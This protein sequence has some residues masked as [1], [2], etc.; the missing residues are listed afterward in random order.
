MGDICSIDPLIA[1]GDRDRV[2]SEVDAAIRENRGFQVEY[3]IIHKDGSPRAF[4]ER[5]QPV[6]DDEGLLSIDGIIQDVTA[7]IAAE[8]EKEKLLH[9]LSQKNAELEQFTYTVSH[10]LKSPLITI[11]GFLGYLEK[12]ALAG[13]TKQLHEDIA[14]IHTATSKMEKFMVALLELSRIGRFVNPPVR[15]SLAFLVQDTVEAL[16]AQ[17]RERGVTLLIP[18]DLPEIYGDRVRLQQVMTNL[19]ENA[20]KFMGDREEPRIEISA[21][22]KEGSVHVCIQDNGIGIAP[23]N[24]DKV[25]SV[26]TRLDP[27]IP[28]SGIGLAL[29]RRII[30][31]HGGQCQV[32]SAGAGMGSTFCFTLPGVPVSRGNTDPP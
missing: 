5:G 15:V 30:E 16:D 10:D 22:Q 8:E 28:G 4:I 11:K 6:Y 3:H 23:E 31:V 1:P 17:I 18:G 26:F 32:E 19:I 25:F 24:L 14:R 9:D 2:I 29:V 20:V 21:Y 13:D 27:S 12:D 7:R